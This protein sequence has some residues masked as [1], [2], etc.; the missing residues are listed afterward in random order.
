MAQHL[1]VAFI[2]EEDEVELEAVQEMLTPETLL[3]L[4][5]EWV[6]KLHE[7][8]SQADIEIVS[9]LL[10]E[11]REEH[12]AVAKGL[13]KMADEFRFDKIMALAG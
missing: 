8:A 13:Q 12:Q 11:I 10:N 4:P 9:D 6:A 1:G 5:P 2:Y 3:T 7:A